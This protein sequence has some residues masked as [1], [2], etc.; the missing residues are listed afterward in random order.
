MKRL[1]FMVLILLELSGCSSIFL[2]RERSFV[3]VFPRETDLPGWSIVNSQSDENQMVIKDTHGLAEKKLIRYKNYYGGEV[4]CGLL[5]FS[6]NSDAYG[7][8]SQL[9][10]YGRFSPETGLTS[11]MNKKIALE[12]LGKRVFMVKVL[13]Q[14]GRPFDLKMFLKNVG[15]VGQGEVPQGILNFTKVLNFKN[16]YV[17]YN[18]SKTAI[19]ENLERVFHTREG[20]CTVFLSQCNTLA[21]AFEQYNRIISEK[22][23][24]VI[25]SNKFHAAINMENPKAMK[26]IKLSGK[27]ILGA[28]DFSQREEGVKIVEKVE[29]RLYR[30]F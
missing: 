26:Y 5:E 6:S 25:N 7:F 30:S 21:D 18:V 11:Y 13:V 12:F 16:N 23:Y 22:K 15:T 27:F 2:P 24:L 8:F 17:V 19:F 3:E 10:G 28:L 29:E 4:L 14:G 1:A 9:R 20:G